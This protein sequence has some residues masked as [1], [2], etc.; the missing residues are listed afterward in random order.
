M[1]LFH[2]GNAVP[3][4]PPRSIGLTLEFRNEVY[5]MSHQHTCMTV[6]FVIG[7]T[8]DCQVS[9]TR[10]IYSLVDETD[11]PKGVVGEA[12]LEAL[13]IGVDPNG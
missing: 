3:D 6:V 10:N 8:I 7:A 11:F 12:H 13:S 1:R 2:V 4:D 5:F 9:A